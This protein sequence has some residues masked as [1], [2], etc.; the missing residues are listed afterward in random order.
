M[1]FLLKFALFFAHILT[2]TH[3]SITGHIVISYVL[4][5]RR[6]H[7]A[8]LSLLSFIVVG[9]RPPHDAQSRSAPF[10]IT[11]CALSGVVIGRKQALEV[12]M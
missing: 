1:S 6:T 8:C 7:Y 5:F 12:Y 9:P 10:D 4:R 2:R 3:C 11:Y